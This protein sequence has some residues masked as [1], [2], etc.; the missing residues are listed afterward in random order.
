[1]LTLCYCR[2]GVP[3][4]SSLVEERQQISGLGPDNRPNQRTA[5]HLQSI[6]RERARLFLYD[7]SKE[8]LH[9]NRD[10]KWL[11]KSLTVQTVRLIVIKTSMKGTNIKHIQEKTAT[12]RQESKNWVICI[13]EKYNMAQVSRAL[14]RLLLVRPKPRDWMVL[15]EFLRSELSGLQEAGINVERILRQKEKEA[16]VAEERHQRQLEQEQ[17]A[18]DE[19]EALQRDLQ[20]EMNIQGGQDRDKNIEEET[21]DL[22]PGNFPGPGDGMEHETEYKQEPEGLFGGFRKMFGLDSARKPQ[23]TLSDGEALAHD[24]AYATEHEPPYSDL[25][26]N[27]KPSSNKPPAPPMTPQQL[28]DL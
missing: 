27:E 26:P 28:H 1:M 20:R 25:E 17:R 23:P 3:G 5:L 10:S 7:Y 21:Q 15:T 16:R 13:T 12:L 11:E 19:L 2:L 6:I 8:S 18:R 24:N 22:M 4:L 14:A 9:P